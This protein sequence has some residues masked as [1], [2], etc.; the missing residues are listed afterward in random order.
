MTRFGLLA[1][2]AGLCVD[3]SLLSPT[4]A[5]ASWG[6]APPSGTTYWL[7]NSGDLIAL[8]RVGLRVRSGNPLSPCFTGIRRSDGGYAG[9]GY[10]Q[11][12]GYTYSTEWYQFKLG[13]KALKVSR[14]SDGGRSDWYYRASRWEALHTAN[15]SPPSIRMLFSDCKLK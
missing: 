6:D 11:N 13:K 15:P 9:G 7:S 3:V 5:Y 2:G 10:N 4:A 1:V 14:S 8:K 12:S